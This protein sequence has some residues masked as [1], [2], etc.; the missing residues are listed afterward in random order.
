MITKFRMTMTSA[1]PVGELDPAERT[2]LMASDDGTRSWQPQGVF[3]N[4]SWYEI[5]RADGPSCR[6]S[7]RAGG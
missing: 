1:N 7:G 5:Q 3:S 6:F 2:V 4:Y